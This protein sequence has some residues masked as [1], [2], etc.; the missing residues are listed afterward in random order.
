LTWLERCPGRG[1]QGFRTIWDGPRY[2]RGHGSPSQRAFEP[3]PLARP[4]AWE[5][6]R[7]REESRR[8]PLGC[9]PRTWSRA[10]V[11]SAPVGSG[12]F[13]R[14]GGDLQEGLGA[15]G[16]QPLLNSLSPSPPAAPRAHGPELL[17]GAPLW[18]QGASR[19]RGV[20]REVAWAVRAR[21][22]SSACLTC[23][24]P[25]QLLHPKNICAI[26]KAWT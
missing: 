5:R 2:H 17:S 19:G 10:L 13:A 16:A 14:R 23:P 12:G 7:L 18:G 1:V 3:P 21:R 20:R 11:G 22:A 25:N 26:L 6:L 4:P 8:G 24:E 15:F 9:A